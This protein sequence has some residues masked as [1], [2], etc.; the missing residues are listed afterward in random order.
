MLEECGLPYNVIPVNIARGDQFKPAF[1]KISPNNRMP[2]IVD[3]DGPGGRPISV[4]ES[5]AIL[6]YLGRKTGKFYPASERARVAGRRVAVLADGQSRAQG[7][8]GEPLPPLC[9]AEKHALRDRALRQRDEPA[10]RR[11]EHAAE[12][13]RVPRRPLFDRR[14]GLRR[15]DQ[16]VPSAKGD[17]TFAALPASQALA[18]RGA[19]AAGGPARHAHPRRGGEPGRRARIPRCAPCCSASA[20]GDA[21]RIAGLRQRPATVAM[22]IG[23]PTRGLARHHRDCENAAGAA[24]FVVNGRLRRSTDVAPFT[25]D[26]SR[27]LNHHSNFHSMIASSD[28]DTGR[29]ASATTDREAARATGESEHGSI[30]KCLNWRWRDSARRRSRPTRCSSSA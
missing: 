29:W 19:R 7:R 5:G 11:D 12:G 20:R 9:A 17:R 28:R 13:S 26:S 8:R 24:V 30:W 27:R 4:F 21:A 25:L 1:L 14:H 16:A 18:R 6:Q 15:L 2:A 3:P 22:V 23:W 10:L